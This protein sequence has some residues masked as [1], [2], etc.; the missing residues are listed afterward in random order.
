MI[1]LVTTTINIIGNGVT[2]IASPSAERLPV[3]IVFMNF[4]RLFPSTVLFGAILSAANDSQKLTA[5]SD[6]IIAER[7]YRRIRD[8]SKLRIP[9]SNAKHL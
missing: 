3:C 1:P 2:K 8:E 4:L 9:Y 7:L 6:G 5:V